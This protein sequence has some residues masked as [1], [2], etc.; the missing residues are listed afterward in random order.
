[1]EVTFG[2]GAVAVPADGGTEVNMDDS[3]FVAWGREYRAA[4]AE[5]P[6][7]PSPASAPAARWIPV[8]GTAHWAST[9]LS[10]TRDENAA[11]ELVYALAG[12]AEVS[13][14]DMDWKNLDDGDLR[15][16]QDWT[17]TV[18]VDGSYFL[19]DH[20]AGACQSDCW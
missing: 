1:M 16:G 15:L 7:A 17:G 18:A 12:V 10:W 8:G 9:T 5:P 11:D 20:G 19:G 4:C 6:A 14:A 13:L 3:A 2:A